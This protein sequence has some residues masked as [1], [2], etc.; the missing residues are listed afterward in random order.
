[1]ALHVQKWN[2]S[3]EVG[4]L[5]SFQYALQ[6]NHVEFLLSKTDCTD[7]YLKY[8]WINYISIR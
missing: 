6:E 1:M 5:A 7:L 2:H 3:Y 4:V 8:S